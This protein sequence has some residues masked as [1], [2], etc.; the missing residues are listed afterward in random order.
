[1]LRTTFTALAG[2]FTQDVSFIERL[3]DSIEKEYNGKGRYYHNLTHLENLLAQLQDV[4]SQIEDF[5]TVLF[6][7]FYHD[8]IYK[9]T[10]KDNEEKSADTAVSA[11]KEIG[12][13]KDKMDKCAAII[14]AT[15][16]HSVS[17]DSDTNLFTDADLSILGSDWEQY[18]AYFKNVR[19]E[20][21]VYPDLLYNPGR[22]K[23]LNH[24][25]EMGHIFKT[26]FFRAKYESVA[27]ENIR[28]EIEIL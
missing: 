14:L 9:S 15:K 17:A 4:K 22:K 1:M 11:L 10:E 13:P 7:L 25:L 19:K 27:R 2:H 23:V 26:N 8:I 6:A 3:W 12:Y 18:S 21:S 20:Y 5:D 16:S 24:F 28:R